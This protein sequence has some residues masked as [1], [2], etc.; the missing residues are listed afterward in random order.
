MH[1]P[2]KLGGEGGGVGAAPVAASVPQKQLSMLCGYRPLLGKKR[3]DACREVTRNRQK[4]G[5]DAC[6]VPALTSSRSSGRTDHVMIA[7]PSTATAIPIPAAN[8]SNFSNGQRPA[9]SGQ[10]QHPGAR[11]EPASAR[12]F[13][14]RFSGGLRRPWKSSGWDRLPRLPPMREGLRGR[15]A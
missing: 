12:A 7:W 1:W 10:R 4:L 8:F 14:G 11:A 2:A 9:A 3:A 13:Q 15:S 5:K 6:A